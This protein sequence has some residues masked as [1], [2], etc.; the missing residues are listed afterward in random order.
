MT[1]NF[2]FQV[3]PKT[4]YRL[5]EALGAMM[6]TKEQALWLSPKP[7]TNM[8]LKAKDVVYL[9]ESASKR[10]TRPGH[11]VARGE[12]T[13]APTAPMDMPVWQRKFCVDA[14]T[15]QSGPQFHNKTPRAEVG[16]L[17]WSTTGRDVDRDDTDANPILRKNPF[18][19]KKGGF[20]TGTIFRLTWP[21]AQ[22]LD[23]LAG[24]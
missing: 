8:G 13:Q 18:F 4:E 24:W 12:V 10:P 1:N 15:G 7:K 11:L 16:I 22:E 14:A 6:Q 9:W 5:S 2:I 3:N 20:Y 23:K 21:E 17:K 19:L